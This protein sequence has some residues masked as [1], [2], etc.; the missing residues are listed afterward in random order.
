MSS[1]QYP[2]ETLMNLER[3]LGKAGCPV[4]CG[5][6]VLPRSS[7]RD[8]HCLILLGVMASTTKAMVKSHVYQ[9][10]GVK[11][12]YRCPQISSSFF[13]FSIFFFLFFLFVNIILF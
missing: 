3:K 10:L 11:D 6:L 4:P 7:R 1:N 13:F 2:P 9:L 12:V 8:L 5:V